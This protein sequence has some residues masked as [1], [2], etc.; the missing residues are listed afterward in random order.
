MSHTD[1]YSGTERRYAH[2][3]KKCSNKDRILRYQP[4]HALPCL[5]SWN[6]RDVAMRRGSSK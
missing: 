1:I 6:D 2:G 3:G 5:Q 4:K